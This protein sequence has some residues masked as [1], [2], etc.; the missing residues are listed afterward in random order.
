MRG[1]PLRMGNY[2]VYILQSEV[3]QGYYVGYTKN[4]MRRLD[5][6][7]SGR[8]KSLKHRLPLALIYSESYSNKE[9]AKARELQI[10]S[11]KGGAPFKALIEG[12]PRLRRGSIGPR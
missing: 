9:S 8:T 7:N 3:D 4:L 5:E 1:L 10:K 12:S 11:W 6:H 2:H